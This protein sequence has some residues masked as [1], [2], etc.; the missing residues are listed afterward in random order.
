MGFAEDFLVII[1]EDIDK[2]RSLNGLNHLVGVG[3]IAHRIAHV[4][5][6]VDG[7]V[8]IGV[9]EDGFERGQVTVNIG[10]E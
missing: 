4:E 1:P 8:F 5:D 2:R 9:A 7:G 3:A 10:D 6:L